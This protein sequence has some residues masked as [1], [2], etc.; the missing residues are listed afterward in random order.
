MSE[1]E[2]HKND[3]E[4]TP[5]NFQENSENVFE[6]PKIHP[7]GKKKKPENAEIQKLRHELGIDTQEE[8][9]LEKEKLVGEILQQDGIWLTVSLPANLSKKEENGFQEFA[10]RVDELFGISN[11]HRQRIE[12]QLGGDLWIILDN[13]KINE[14]IDIRVGKKEIIET[15]KIPGKKG[16]LGFGKL[17]DSFEK[18]FTDKYGELTQNQI[19]TGGNNEPAFIFSYFARNGK[20]FKDAT[21]NRVGILC[22]EFICPESR[23]LILEK[24]VQEDPT[25]IRRLVEKS[26]RAM[27]GEMFKDPNDINTGIGGGDPII[28][29]WDKWDADPSGG[30][31]YIQ[32]E[33]EQNGW[34]EEFVHTIKK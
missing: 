27:K 34:H 9:E 14:L 7:L 19:V 25:V 11:E 5:P 10:L 33:G 30:R 20:Y 1:K 32:K 21:G 18:R 17:P 26:I 29:K 2:P 3:Q 22:L 16:F 4:P 13:H 8:K 28:P 23:A 24:M 31:I 15:V 12:K 6:P